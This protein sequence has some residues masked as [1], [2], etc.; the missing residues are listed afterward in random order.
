MSNFENRLNPVH[1]YIEL[2]EKYV[3][4]AFL[5]S[6]VIYNFASYMRIGPFP[7]AQYIIALFS[8]YSFFMLALSK[9]RYSKKVILLLLAQPILTTLLV[10]IDL[11][12]GRFNFS[13]D[14]VKA[15]I[16][17]FP[18]ALLSF[19]VSKNYCSEKIMKCWVLTVFVSALFAI[20][21]K[22][23]IGSAIQIRD[24]I[25][26]TLYPT[27]YRPPGLHY[28]SLTLSYALTVAIPFCQYLI[29]KS[30]KKKSLSFIQA[31]LT[32]AVVIT[33]SRV[34]MLGV[35]LF[36]FIYYFKFNK[37]N[38]L[39]TL[40][41]LITIFTITQTSFF[42]KQFPITFLHFEDRFFIY[43]TAL[44]ISSKNWIYGIGSGIIHY[45]SYVTELYGE[46]NPNVPEYVYKMSPHSH[47]ISVLLKTGIIGLI[48]YFF[49]LFNFIKLVLTITDKKLRI[50]ILITFLNLL[51]TSLTH[52]AGF[53]NHF[54][55][56]Y[57][58]YISLGITQ[59][60]GGKTCV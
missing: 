33:Q 34:S 12:L 30:S 18:L 20:F 55:F 24:F 13:L 11:S 45:S 53:L 29:T 31:C 56:V 42:K 32:V 6:I 22:I 26:V 1:K 40:F 48:F 44:L 14:L 51:L 49:C 2:I 36:F 47:P 8:I 27:G 4:I 21:Q 16:K 38:I 19:Y 54:I 46:N 50:I 17:F 58:L 23:G 57:F 3:L 37:K 25:G 9:E 39:I 28:Y 7:P 59:K 10:V 41:I 60:D 15:L 43:K 52:N 5:S 35:F